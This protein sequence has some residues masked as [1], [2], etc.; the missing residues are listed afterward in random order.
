MIERSSTPR[1]HITMDSHDEH[2]PQRPPMSS[3]RRWMRRA[4]LS[5][6]A[7]GGLTAAGLGGPLAG[8]ALGAQPT[9]PGP[10][11]GGGGPAEDT[12]TSSSASTPAPD[13]P[14]QGGGSE[15][16]TTTTATTT[17]P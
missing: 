1:A 4:M 2:G 7:G 15:T 6:L 11:T 12:V 17:A 5:A 8:G 9:S 16:T 14:A 3:P 13:A 10:S